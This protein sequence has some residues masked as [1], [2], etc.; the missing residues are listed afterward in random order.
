MSRSKMLPLVLYAEDDLHEIKLCKAALEDADVHFRMEFVRDGIQLM[1]YL[2]NKDDFQDKT[3]YRRPDLLMIDL[4]MPG[5]D[6][7]ECLEEIK[8]DRDLC[9]IPVIIFS[10]SNLAQ[11]I[12]EMY[13]LGASSYITKPLHFLDLVKVFEAIDKYWI[14]IVCLPG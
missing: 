10:T 2:H 4:N 11:V 6:G 3:L 13:A 5:K 9:S 14:K 7:R 8:A 12:R 1:N